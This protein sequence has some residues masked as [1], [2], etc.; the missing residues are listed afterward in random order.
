MAQIMP[1]IISFQI[2]YITAQYNEDGGVEDGT[3]A[4]L[5]LKIYSQKGIQCI[6]SSGKEFSVSRNH[7]R[8]VIITPT[9]LTL[10]LLS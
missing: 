9:L 2:V 1:D 8:C 10:S 7:R 5:Q 6:R 4:N 3:S